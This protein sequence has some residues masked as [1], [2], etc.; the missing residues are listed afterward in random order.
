MRRPK[1]RRR[2]RSAKES[3]TADQRG[4]LFV[5]LAVGLWLIT[6]TILTGA[7]PPPCPS[8]HSG[9][10]RGAGAPG[11][12]EEASKVCF[13]GPLASFV[14]KNFDTRQDACWGQ[15]R[16]EAVCS[17][18]KAHTRQI[19]GER[20]WWWVRRGEREGTGDAH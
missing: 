17:P 4:G 15:L 7:R 3:K 13:S 20:G 5:F 12:G 10:A 8:L 14:G 16:D 19:G 6:L 11:R 9:R 2:S 1:R 18:S